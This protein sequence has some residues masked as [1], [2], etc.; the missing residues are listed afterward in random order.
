MVQRLDIREN[1]EPWRRA[2]LNIKE[3]RTSLKRIDEMQRLLTQLKNE[4][5]ASAGLGHSQ[6]SRNLY[7]KHYLLANMQASV[8]RLRSEAAEL[9]S[10]ERGLAT[11]AHKVDLDARIREQI[12]EQLKKK[13]QVVFNN[14]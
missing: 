12:R 7:E 2:L 9:E 11:L 1:S 5:E 3:M 8:D 6:D 14:K 4:L 13:M 10:L